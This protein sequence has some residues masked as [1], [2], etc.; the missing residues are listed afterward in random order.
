MKIGLILLGIYF[1]ILGLAGMPNYFLEYPSEIKN[2]KWIT[3][4]QSLILF[5]S[6]LV[7]L[8]LA[9]NLKQKFD[10]T[11]EKHPIQIHLIVKLLGLFFIVDTS[12]EVANA[13]IT[14]ISATFDPFVILNIFIPP[15]IQFLAGLILVLYSPTVIEK[16][17]NEK[18]T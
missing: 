8:F 9:K 12:S 2:I 13:L 16:F 4:S 1:V 18:R 5:L 6:G 11:F 3:F 17:L 15:L 14:S 10:I 7:L